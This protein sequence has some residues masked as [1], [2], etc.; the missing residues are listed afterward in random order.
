MIDKFRKVEEEF[1]RLKYQ[2]MKGIINREEFRKRLEKLMV[3]DEEG[4]YWMIGVQ[5]GKWY[6]Y[7]GKQWIQSTPPFKEEEMKIICYS[8]ERENEENAIFCVFCG[9]KLK[10][11]IKICLRCGNSL[12]DEYSFCPMCGL[13]IED[14][15]KYLFKFKNLV[16]GP[17]FPFVGG[18]GLILGAIIGIFMGASNYF[19][20]FFTFLPF[21]LRDIHG[22]FMGSLIFGIFGGILGFIL[23]GL[24]GLLFSLLINFISFL[25]G[26]F[27]IIFTSK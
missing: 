4:R 11:E 2:L 26:G 13:S 7:N 25:F 1:H 22:G 14:E 20:R 10:E 16:I 23:I 9:I 15:K 19:Y 5:S 6:Y 8:C 12:K 18:I 27:K 17:S 3:K 24:I 21:F